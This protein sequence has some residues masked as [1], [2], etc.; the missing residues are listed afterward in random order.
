MTK[1]HPPYCQFVPPWLLERLA[2]PGDRTTMTV[3][4]VTQ[5]IEQTLRTDAQIRAS[6]EAAPPH[7]TKRATKPAWAVYTAASKQTLPGKLM[8]TAGD[9]DS[10]DPAVNEAATGGQAALDLFSQ[11]YGRNSYDN[12]GAEVIMSVHYGQRYDN[13]FWNGTQLVFGD[14][15]GT[16]FDR[17]TKPVDVLAHELSHAVTEHTAGLVY[18]DEPGALNESMSDVFGIC[19]KQRLLGQ[20]AQQADWLIGEGIFL[21]GVKARA[22]RDM[23]HPGT[24]YD[25]PKLGKDPQVATYADYDH[26]T[27]DNGGVHINS[28][29]PNRAFQLAATGIGGS[30]AE[31]AGKIWYAALTGKNVGPNTDFAG[32][33]AATVAA[34][35]T[36]ADVVRQ[37]WTTVGVTPA[38]RST[39]A[40][41][42]T[43]A[44]ASVA[45]RRSGGFAGMTRTGEL[46]L[47]G[48]DPRVTTVRRIV[49]RTDFTAFSATSSVPDAFSYTF[50]LP[51]H[52]EVTVA[53]H[54]LTHDLRRLV[55]LL[56]DQE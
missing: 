49:Q 37:A 15:D 48:D 1:R 12:A 10:T 51:D 9:P 55:E 6:R 42:T 2:E 41:S 38:A 43:A 46:N 27:G 13:A 11:V 24:A 3:D 44:P 19:A 4:L 34:A 8:R 36:N 23:A 30:S 28:G 16:I 45:V 5:A 35:G 47:E 22:L 32:F 18:S 53:E 26:T 17:F 50:S 39:S 31:G 40:A 54:E 21:P 7:A 20:T 25:D 14:G 29:I 52:E 56:L 33:A